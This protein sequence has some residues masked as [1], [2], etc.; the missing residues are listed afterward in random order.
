MTKLGCTRSYGAKVKLDYTFGAVI[1]SRGFWKY[2]IEKCIGGQMVFTTLDSVHGGCIHSIDCLKN[3][4]FM[5]LIKGDIVEAWVIIE[6]DG[7]ETR[8]NC[9]G[10][11]KL[12]F[13]QLVITK[14]ED[15]IH[16]V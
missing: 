10:P 9:I 2:R 16:H 12:L 4:P 5:N 6:K 13:I 14:K 3:R 15:F 7:K 8:L 1:P 11:M